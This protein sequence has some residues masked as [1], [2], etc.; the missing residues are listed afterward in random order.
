MKKHFKEYTWQDSSHNATYTYD[1]PGIYWLRVI[2]T[3]GCMGSDTLKVIHDCAPQ[4]Y[5]PNAFI[6]GG[7]S[8]NNYFKAVGSNVTGFQMG[9]YN[10][11]GQLIFQ[12]EDINIGW[13]GQY[14]NQDL[15]EGI[16]VYNISYEGLVNTKKVSKKLIGKVLLIR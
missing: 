9:I 13:N 1:K 11:W 12:S 3:N 5:I 4:L 6:P 2:D 16:F 10:R 7:G 15:A 8:S 14:K